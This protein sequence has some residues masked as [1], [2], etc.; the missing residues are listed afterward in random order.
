MLP[1]SVLLGMSYI[2]ETHIQERLADFFLKEIT[3]N[4]LIE[5]DPSGPASF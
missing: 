4:Y 3:L 1:M 2:K 5:A